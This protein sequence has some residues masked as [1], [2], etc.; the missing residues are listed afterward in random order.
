MSNKL[1]KKE[2]QLSHHDITYVKLLLPLSSRSVKPAVKEFVMHVMGVFVN[3]THWQEWLEIASAMVVVLTSPTE[4][5][6]VDTC[7]NLC[8]VQSMLS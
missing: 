5:N 2:K 7:G 6:M 1:W 3:C 8:E 4:D